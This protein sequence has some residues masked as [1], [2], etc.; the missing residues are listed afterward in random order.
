MDHNASV[1]IIIVAAIAAVVIWHWI[2]AKYRYSV[3]LKAR[4]DAV[5]EQ[6]QNDA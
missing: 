2:N 6:K 1:T 3:V 5:Q 4:A